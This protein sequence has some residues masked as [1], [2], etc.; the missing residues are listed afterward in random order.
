MR[1]LMQHARMH[2]EQIIWLQVGFLSPFYAG[3][4]KSWLAAVG[5]CSVRHADEGICLM[6]DLKY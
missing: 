1:S 6:F 5:M 4:S 2:F 3:P